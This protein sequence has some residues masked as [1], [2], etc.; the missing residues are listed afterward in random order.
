M[1]KRIKFVA[2]LNGIY[3]FYSTNSTGGLGLKQNGTGGLGL[4]QNGTGGAR[5][6]A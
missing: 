5:I 6:K 4:K 1:I 2:K 3:N